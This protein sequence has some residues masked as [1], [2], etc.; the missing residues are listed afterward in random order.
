[1]RNF[2][3]NAQRNAAPSSRSNGY[4]KRPQRR[5]V[6]PTGPVIERK[7]APVLH[8]DSVE[9]YFRTLLLKNCN[10]KT[11]DENFF[12]LHQ[13]MKST[14]DHG[15]PCNLKDLSMFNLYGHTVSAPIKIEE[16]TFDAEAWANLFFRCLPDLQFPAYSKEWSVPLVWIFNNIYTSIDGIDRSKWITQTR[17]FDKDAGE[18]A[19][20][21]DEYDRDVASAKARREEVT[22]MLEDTIGKNHL[23]EIPSISM[24]VTIPE[25]HGEEQVYSFY[26][27]R[28]AWT[29][30]TMRANHI[31][32]GKELNK[33]TALINPSKCYSAEEYAD[34]MK[35]LRCDSILHDHYGEELPETLAMLVQSTYEF[36]HS[37]LESTKG[38]KCMLA[39]RYIDNIVSYLNSINPSA[40]RAPVRIPK[41]QRTL[42]MLKNKYSEKTKVEITTILQ[43]YSKETLEKYL[44]DYFVRSVNI[45]TMFADFVLMFKLFDVPVIQK[46]ITGGFSARSQKVRIHQLAYA[47]ILGIFGTEVLYDDTYLNTDE[48]I[49]TLLLAVQSGPVDIGIRVLQ[50]TETMVMDFDKSMTSRQ[51]TLMKDCYE[52][53]GLRCPI[54]ECPL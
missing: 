15:K 37:A 42:T 46:A 40:S 26:S 8:P 54:S 16:N 30:I 52:K 7:S 34:G 14:F 44:L 4:S 20:S 31:N 50:K 47:I 45:N 3:R 6:N 9:I 12:K 39:L 11:F 36:H 41:I 10:A 33:F 29:L 22:K 18:M 13:I 53:T 35:S 48:R 27:I 38:N 21:H 25:F 32:F 5:E 17:T 2:K 49:E 28:L 23:K 43:S 19:R 51:K 24:E 1:M